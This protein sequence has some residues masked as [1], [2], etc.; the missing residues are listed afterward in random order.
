MNGSFWIIWYTSVLSKSEMRRMCD[1]VYSTKL[2]SEHGKP[3]L[4]EDRGKQ[5]ALTKRFKNAMKRNAQNWQFAFTCGQN[6]WT[7]TTKMQ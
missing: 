4:A 7:Y 2:Q 3:S 6:F 1:C 5:L